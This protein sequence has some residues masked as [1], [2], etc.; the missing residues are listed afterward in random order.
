MIVE[1][2]LN[3]EV[4]EDLAVLGFLFDHL[5]VDQIP[6]PAKG[7]G[8][9]EAP[10]T[11]AEK[12]KK[13]RG[14]K[15]KQKKGAEDKTESEIKEMN[16]DEMNSYLM[17]KEGD[18]SEFEIRWLTKIYRKEHDVEDVRSIINELG[19]HNFTDLPKDQYKKFTLK[20]C[21]KYARHQTDADEA[22]DDDLEI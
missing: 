20:L 8:E 3:T 15:P 10:E 12:P 6:D 11:P 16:F 14:R 7:K 1:F 4:K 21:E 9:T 19:G 18:P 5:K 22:A 17:H 13:K 2:K